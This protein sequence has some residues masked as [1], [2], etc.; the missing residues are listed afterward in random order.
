MGRKANGFARAATAVVVIAV[1]AA[2]GTTAD[3]AEK[4]IGVMWMGESGIAKEV[5]R[6]FLQRIKAE[7]PGI[8]MDFKIELPG[9]DAA[10]AVYNKWQDEKDGIVFLRSSG[11][12]YMGNHPP[13][14]PAFIGGCSH[15]GIL[16]A[17]ENLEMPEG[18]ITGVTYYIDARKKV[19]I[20]K[21]VLPGMRRL[22]LVVEVAHPSAAIDRSE[23][24]A[25]CQMLNIDYREALCQT[26]SEV[27]IKGK[28]LAEQVDLI[29]MGSQALVN[30]SIPRLAALIETPMAT[31]LDQHIEGLGALCGLAADNEKLGRML[32]DSVV[33]VLIDGK[34]IMA[35]PVKLDPDPVFLLNMSMVKKL[36]ITVPP[37]V[38]SMA[39]KV[40]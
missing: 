34:P 7:A 1:M 13:R 4:R 2:A 22:G 3:A 39:E 12:R 27:L 24:R 16:G 33:S 40:N 28:K 37:D 35:V 36:G 21:R 18:K 30:S 9:Q 17:V 10:A 6:G 38:L 20:F 25:A 32:A 29:V 15:P 5:A 23:T 14:I 31:Y 11:A 19:E 8:D 26:E